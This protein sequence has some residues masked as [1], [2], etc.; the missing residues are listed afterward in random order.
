MKVT[1]TPTL[2][3]RAPAWGLL[4]V[5]TLA[6]FALGELL[7]LPA[8]ALLAGIASGSLLSL[9]ETGITIPS[10]LFHLSQSILGLRISLSFTLDVLHG[11]SDNWLMAVIIVVAVILFGFAGGMMITVKQWL[12]GTTGIWGISPGGATAM[13]VMSEACGG[14]MRLVAVMQYLRVII[15]I[16]MAIGV[17]RFLGTEAPASIEPAFFD[18]LFATPA[19]SDLG[20]TFALAVI[21]CW[22]ARLSRVPAASFLLPMFVGAV[23]QNA[24]LMVIALPIWL[25]TLVFICIGWSIGLRFN[26]RIFMYTYRLMP[27]ILGAIFFMVGSAGILAAILVIG[28][29][30]D[31]LTAYLATS[32][33]GADAVAI[34]AASGGGDMVF[35]MAAQT[36]RLLAVILI[37]PYLARTAAHFVR[38]RI[39]P[40]ADQR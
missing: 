23:L 22:L 19:F 16:V 14:D 4:V 9:R 39:P 28:W 17:A 24:G 10:P 8:A 40:S 13:I 3:C 34:I 7:H 18:G 11:M 15:V 21:C 26:R 12:P 29:D 30:I 25:L 37:G 2:S 35:I 5:L 36:L 38:R 27:K 32:P 33:G 20:L 6:V 1:N 31:P